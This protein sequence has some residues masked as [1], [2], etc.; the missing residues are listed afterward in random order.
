MEGQ[1][2]RKQLLKLIDIVKPPVADLGIG[3]PC[4]SIYNDRLGADPSRSKFFDSPE[5]SWLGEPRCATGIPLGARPWLV[6]IVLWRLATTANQLTRWVTLEI[7]CGNE[8]EFDDVFL[9]QGGRLCWGVLRDMFMAVEISGVLCKIHVGTVCCSSLTF[10]SHPSVR[11]LLE[12]WKKST[13]H[14]LFQWL[15]ASESRPQ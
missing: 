3:A 1:L 11:I 5:V 14:D 7:A 15:K 4:H 10:V 13:K 8:G 6:K 12:Q 2:V 9:I